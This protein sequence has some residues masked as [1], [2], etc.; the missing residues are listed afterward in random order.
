[1]RRDDE[2]ARVGDAPERK[3]GSQWISRKWVVGEGI[4]KREPRTTNQKSDNIIS[5]ILFNTMSS[6][7]S[8]Q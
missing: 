3:R 5:V 7:N 1:M 2:V 6:T 8:L 4:A